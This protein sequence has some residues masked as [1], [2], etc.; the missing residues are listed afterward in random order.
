MNSELDQAWQ[1]V[2]DDFRQVCRLKREGQSVESERILNELLPTRISAWSQL[3]PRDPGEKRIQLQSMFEREQRASDAQ[4][5]AENRLVSRLSTSVFSE[6]KEQLRQDL[7]QQF[8]EWLASAGRSATTDDAT[9]PAVDSPRVSSPPWKREKSAST[10]VSATP[11]A[12]IPPPTTPGSLE[13]MAGR[14][15]PAATG[16]RW[17]F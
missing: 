12:P 15:D 8:S 5:E 6:L 7:R 2:V 4:R 11:D 1:N 16:I 17:R 14:T 13:P 10:L 9:P 3:D